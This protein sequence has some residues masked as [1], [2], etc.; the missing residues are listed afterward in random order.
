MI[1]YTRLSTG[2]PWKLS[3]TVQSA[4]VGAKLSTSKSPYREVLDVQDDSKLSDPVA[5]M[6]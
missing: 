3:I 1:E 5:E 2:I 4:K 6:P